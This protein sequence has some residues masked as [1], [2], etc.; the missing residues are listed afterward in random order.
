MSR[1]LTRNKKRHSR[2]TY[3]HCGTGRLTYSTTRDSHL[4][5]FGMHNIYIDMMERRISASILN[6]GRVIDGGKYKYVE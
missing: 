2:F 6:R 4:T 5:S 1:P 3:D